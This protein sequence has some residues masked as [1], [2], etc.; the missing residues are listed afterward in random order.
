[1]RISEYKR[2]VKEA[3]DAEL[4]TMLD[5][6]RES[7]YKLRQQ[8]A[9]KQ[10]ENPKA[11]VLAKRNIARLLSELRERELKILEGS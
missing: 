7:Y 5:Q 2:K 6:E 8:I 9:L 1:M 10:L 11:M 3:T 4:L